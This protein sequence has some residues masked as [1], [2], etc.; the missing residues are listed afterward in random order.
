MVHDGVR[1]SG[2]MS[3]N[4]LCVFYYGR[5]KEMCR[6]FGPCLIQCYGSSWGLGT[7]RV[8]G[9]CSIQC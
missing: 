8:F 4:K 2:Q 9:P 3:I 5:S 7:C 1:A 6:I